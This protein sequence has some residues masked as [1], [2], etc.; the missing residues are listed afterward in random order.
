MGTESQ[1]GWRVGIDKS[2][3][4]LAFIIQ[5]YSVAS[6][7]EAEQEG[8]MNQ[9]VLVFFF[10]PRRGLYYNSQTLQCLVL[11]QS[12]NWGGGWE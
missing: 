2:T 3:Q 9:Y 6:P 1:L 5:N 12:P 7:L 11:G 8:K 4:H 10:M